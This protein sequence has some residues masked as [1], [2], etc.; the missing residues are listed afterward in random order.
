MDPKREA[1]FM[2]GS[3]VFLVLLGCLMLAGKL[4]RDYDAAKSR[5]SA[6]AA[7]WPDTSRQLARLMLERYGPPDSLSAQSMEWDQRWPWTKVT[8]SAEGPIASLTQS[9][10]CRIPEGKAAELARFPHGLT[11]DAARGTLAA[12]SD[13]ESLNFL[14]LNLGMDIIAGRRTPEAASRAFDR[15]VELYYA[16]KSVPQAERLLFEVPPPRQPAG[17]LWS[18]SK[19]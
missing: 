1:A 11:A 6:Q 15:A 3:A 2:A 13:R 16:G 12:R 7:Q 10:F 4:S 8:V 9:V 17:R 14:S 19:L 18:E 5:A